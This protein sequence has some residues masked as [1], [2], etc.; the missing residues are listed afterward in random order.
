MKSLSTN[1]EALVSE[2]VMT[3]LFTIAAI[4]STG[5][6]HA[7]ERREKNSIISSVLQGKQRPVHEAEDA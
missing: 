2:M 6:D 4:R 1:L 5:A 7:K 3:S